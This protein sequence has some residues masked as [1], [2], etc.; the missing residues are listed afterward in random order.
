MAETALR[1]LCLIGLHP[2][3]GWQFV[4]DSWNPDLYIRVCRE[5]G[6]QVYDEEERDA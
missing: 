2:R 5:C 4:G 1:A 6:H 3:R